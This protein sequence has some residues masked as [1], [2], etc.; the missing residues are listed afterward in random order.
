[1]NKKNFLSATVLAKETAATL[2]SLENG[3]RE[4]L[5]ILENNEPK[6]VML[7]IDAYEEMEEEIEDLRLTSLALARF[8]TFDEKNAK[9][10]AHM[11]ERFVK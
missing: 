1:M 10:H 7:S 8:H 9:S 6:A 11:M 5:I 3:S 4:K 2:D